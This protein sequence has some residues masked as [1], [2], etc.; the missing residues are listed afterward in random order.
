MWLLVSHFVGQCDCRPKFRHGNWLLVGAQPRASSIL[1]HRK[2]IIGKLDRCA[3]KQTNT[4]IFSRTSS[5]KREVAVSGLL[6]LKLVWKA[7][8]F[9]KKVV[10][11]WSKTMVSSY[12]PSII[13]RPVFLVEAK[14]IWW[15]LARQTAWSLQRRAMAIWGM[16]LNPKFTM[17]VGCST[18]VVTCCIASMNVEKS[19]SV[20]CLVALDVKSMQS[21]D[22]LDLSWPQLWST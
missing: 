22:S 13:Q 4:F 7:V 21:C 10:S 20:L 11:G 17:V 6:T 15:S 18:F 2:M 9:G 8:Y 1:F 14:L 16:S 5:T 3:S 12:V 19:T